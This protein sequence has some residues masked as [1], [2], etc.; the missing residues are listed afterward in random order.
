MFCVQ[1][2]GSATRS[3]TVQEIIK[4]SIFRRNKENGTT[5][6]LIHLNINVQFVTHTPPG[7]LPIFCADMSVNSLQNKRPEFTQSTKIFSPKTVSLMSLSRAGS[8]A[9]LCRLMGN[10]GTYCIFRRKSRTGV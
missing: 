2:S 3:Q 7:L 4:L 5:E 1:R 9:C 10:L 6:L 8:G